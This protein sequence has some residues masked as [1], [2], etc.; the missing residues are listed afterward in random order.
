[1]SAPA[2]RR[3]GELSGLPRAVRE[4]L[5]IHGVLGAGHR[6]AAAAALLVPRWLGELAGGLPRPV[7]RELEAAQL[8]LLCG[9]LLHEALLDGPKQARFTAWDAATLHARAQERLA[10]LFPPGDPFWRGFAKVLREQ[11]ASARWELRMRGRRPRFGARL[12]RAL[13]SK[14]ALLR[15]PAF[16]VPRL[17]GGRTADRC[18]RLLLRLFIAHQ[19]LDD[20]LDVDQDAARGQPNAV[21]AALGM[22]AADP[23]DR[24][25]QRARARRQV[26]AAARG[27]L[28][29]LVRALPA[30][31][32]LSR[33]CGH[34]LRSCDELEEQAGEIAALG[35]AAHVLEALL[36]PR[37]GPGPR[38][39]AARTCERH[40]VEI[41]NET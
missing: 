12:L 41:R 34:L 16:A 28:R 23:L 33:H 36:G 37:R 1:V 11:A 3:E 21:L 10:S 14:A 30:G 13:G 38:D 6:S 15:W 31:C 25:R 19:L 7:L 18:D 17:C 20:L 27:Q 40:V 22:P 26:C 4:A 9:G 24:E 5:P 32:G 8:L 39:P 35:A 29:A 2:L